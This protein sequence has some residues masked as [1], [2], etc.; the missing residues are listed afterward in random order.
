MTSLTKKGDKNKFL[1]NLN[2]LRRDAHLVYLSKDGEK[3][4]R[5]NCRHRDKKNTTSSPMPP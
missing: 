2:N 4:E 5:S 3:K 1:I